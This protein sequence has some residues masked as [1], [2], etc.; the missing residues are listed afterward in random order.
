MRRANA[1]RRLTSARM[2]VPPSRM[3]RRGWRLQLSK[4][5]S[6]A[7]VRIVKTITVEAVDPSWN[8]LERGFF[9]PRRASVLDLEISKCRCVTPHFMVTQLSRK[10]I[11]G[12]FR[13]CAAPLRA[14]RF[15]SDAFEACRFRVQRFSE[16][17][18]R[19]D[20]S[21]RTSF[22]LSRVSRREWFPD[23]SS[24]EVSPDEDASGGGGLRAVERVRRSR[25]HADER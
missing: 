9:S 22:H 5:P 14:M 20:E 24:I 3:A 19:A 8:G 2:P 21:R 23:N 16:R 15:R 25:V 1:A 4:H 7:C 13:R 17:R 10:A 11:F 18:G 12:L 6:C